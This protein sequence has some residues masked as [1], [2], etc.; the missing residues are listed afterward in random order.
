M[1]HAG[2]DERHGREGK[3]SGFGLWALGYKPLKI[4]IRLDQ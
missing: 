3:V 1:A 2:G 4:V